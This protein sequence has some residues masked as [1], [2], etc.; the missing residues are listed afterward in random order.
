[1]RAA[2]RGQGG[3][4]GRERPSWP[5]PHVGPLYLHVCP[6]QRSCSA[7]QPFLPLPLQSKINE[8]KDLMKKKAQEIEKTKIEA[9]KGGE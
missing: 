2:F 9:A 5:Y 7:G 3:R 8:T 6:L 4:E 1:M